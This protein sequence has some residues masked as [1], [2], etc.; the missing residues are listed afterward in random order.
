[1]R[2]GFCL[3]L[4]LVA[5]GGSSKPAAPPTT[6]TATSTETTTTTT[7]ETTKPKTTFKYPAPFL[8]PDCA[9]PQAEGY[10]PNAKA[11]VAEVRKK[12]W[13][14]LEACAEAAPE[15]QDLSGEIRTS[16]RLDQDGV[17]RC[18]E[19]PGAP[20]T[21]EDVVRCVISVYRTFRFPAPKNGSVR[22]TDGI[23]LS[24]SHD[25]ED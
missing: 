12:N 14:R 3:V 17:P 11:A 15:G 9:T 6:E 20:S 25:E 4:L 5:C 18:V 24:V 22:V 8:E 13:S 21:M 23:H 1:M 10:L 16:F 7:V 19:A 2:I